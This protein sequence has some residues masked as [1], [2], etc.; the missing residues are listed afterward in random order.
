MDELKRE[1]RR[2]QSVR[3]SKLRTGGAKG[4]RVGG[5]D[6]LEELTCW[7][8]CWNIL[9]P[10]R[11]V[12]AIPLILLSLLLIISLTITVIDKFEHSSCGPSC[13]YEL[14]S[15]KWVNPI[16][17]ALKGLNKVFP[18]D[19]L[20]FGGLVMYI[21]LACVS[22]IVGLGVRFFIFHLY[23]IQKG[24]T[25]PNGYL[26]M[27]WLLQLIVLALNMEVLTIAPTYASFGN[28]FYLN[29]TSNERHSCDIDL[30]GIIPNTCI[31]T[32]V[33]RFITTMGVETPFFTVILF[34]GNL[35][36]VGF[37]LLFLIHGLTC[38]DNSKK[39]EVDAFRKL[40]ELSD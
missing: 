26:M 4:R 39:E 38:A 31:Q 2:L 22:G 11:L 24:R 34:Y 8:K 15:P 14:S 9:Q 36:F 32:S 7:D 37:F 6:D 10:I 20:A 13:G 18:I 12:I 1:Q 28:Q 35:A 27:A 30:I 21:F 23:S 5:N 25:M 16:D 40:D 17:E 33:G 29:T 19:C 3:Q